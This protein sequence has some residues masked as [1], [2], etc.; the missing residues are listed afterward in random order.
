MS[1]AHDLLH[2]A[3]T[4]VEQQQQLSACQ[5]QRQGAP[6]RSPQGFNREQVRLGR[7]Q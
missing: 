2:A 7:Q 3:A 6:A 5:A 1:V 4:D